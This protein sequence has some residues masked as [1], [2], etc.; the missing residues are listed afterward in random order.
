[1]VPL[2]ETD[3]FEIVMLATGPD[4]F[5]AGG[6]AGVVPFFLTQKGPLELV[7]A[8]VSEQDRLVGLS[9]GQHRHE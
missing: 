5:L 9:G 3:V 7:H 6:R 2:R 1:M 8:G 4:A